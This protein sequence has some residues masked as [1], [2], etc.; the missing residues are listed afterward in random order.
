MSEVYV[1]GRRAPGSE[2]VME[3]IGDANADIVRGLAPA[4]DGQVVLAGYDGGT[5]RAWDAD[6]GRLLCTF[7]RRHSADW[8]VPALAISPLSLA[9]VVKRKPIRIMRAA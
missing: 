3:F 6:S 1:V 5:I 7:P 8:G 2:D 9:I 4:P